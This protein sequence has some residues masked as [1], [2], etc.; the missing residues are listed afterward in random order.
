[1]NRFRAG[2]LCALLC[3]AGLAPVA[4]AGDFAGV[5]PDVAA[6][7]APAAPL[8][9]NSLSSAQQELLKRHAGDWDSLPPPR[10]RALARGAER[11]LG[12]DTEQRSLARE[13]FQTWQGLPEERRELIRRRWER[14]QQ[15]DPQAQ[16][17]IR[18]NYRTFSRLP[19][20]KRQQL[21]RRWLEA[22]PAERARMLD[23]MRERRGRHEP[24]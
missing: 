10:Q 22:T 7:G 14:F 11:W 1:M 9:W 23:R 24:R 4:R 17:L 18:Q 13:R 21:R 2:L 12:M 8:A 20:W 3:L 16:E 15:L 19:P 6:P 5:A